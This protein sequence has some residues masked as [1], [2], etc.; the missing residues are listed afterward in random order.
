MTAR[1]DASQ[2]AAVIIGATL[3]GTTSMVRSLGR[4]GVDLTLIDRR[5]GVPMS[6]RYTDRTVVISDETA[7]AEHDDDERFDETRR[8]P[9]TWLLEHVESTYADGT[10]LLCGSDEAAWFL[11]HNHDRLSERFIV[12]GSSWP[13]VETLWDKATAWQLAES[14]G[15]SVPLWYQPGTVDELES[16]AT[17]LDFEQSSWMIRAEAWSSAATSPAGQLT[18]PAGPTSETLL[19]RSL[20]LHRRT[21]EL[22]TIAEVIPGPSSSCIGVSMVIGPDG[23]TLVEY[24]I[25]R[26]E[27]Y[28]YVA[29]GRDSPNH[30]GGVVHAETMHDS[31]AIDAAGRMAKAAGYRGAVMFEFRR[32]PSGELVFLKVDPRVCNTLAISTAVGQDEAIALYDGFRGRAVDGPGRYQDGVGWIWAGAW[33]YGIPR[34]RARQGLIGQ[35]AG[36]AR[37]APSI[38]ASGDLSLT[39]PVPVLDSL[40]RGLAR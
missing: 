4:R 21:G 8:L 12:A 2:P 31:E 5:H 37:R 27:I 38:R 32:R 20:D 7:A 36:L 30:P 40:R 25:R 23:S 19:E 17:S 18:M 33:A 10:V 26:L 34:R 24:S 14:I 28:P 15:C 29:V 16:I 9:T 1:P 3:P 11:A 6:S 22:P 13:A 35:V 39:D